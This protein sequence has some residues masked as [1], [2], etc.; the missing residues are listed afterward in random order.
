[1]RELEPQKG[2][3][4]VS[5]RCANSSHAL[6]I[7]RFP[8]HKLDLRTRVSPVDHLPQLTVDGVDLTQA[9]LHLNGERQILELI[10]APF[11]CMSRSMTKKMDFADLVM[12]RV[13][14][15]GLLPNVLHVFRNRD[16]Y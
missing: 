7:A 11:G 4:C 9:V 3:K 8:M 1:M 2:A 5:H 6:F 15:V 13:I 10:Y 16:E 14:T 12:D